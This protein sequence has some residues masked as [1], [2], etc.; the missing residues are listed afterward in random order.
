MVT[1]QSPSCQLTKRQMLTRA[2]QV[3]QDAEE[4][5]AR[6]RHRDRGGDG[7]VVGRRRGRHH[8]QARQQGGDPREHGVVAAARQLQQLRPWH[9]LRARERA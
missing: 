5:G 2:Q 3:G 1:N 4:L 7:A 9:V 8:A 6:Q